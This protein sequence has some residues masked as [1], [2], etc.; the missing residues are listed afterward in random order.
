MDKTDQAALLH[1]IGFGEFFLKNKYYPWQEK[2]LDSLYRNKRTALK[3]ANGSGK[4]DKI[5]A[6]A[7]LWWLMG[8]DG[9]KALVTSASW[10]QI[11]TQ[12][13]PAICRHQD[14]FGPGWVINK[15]EIRRPNG[16]Q[17]IAR[18]TNEPGRFEGHH[19]NAENP[20]LIIVDESKTVSD[21]I[22]GAVNRC[23]YQRLLLTSSPGI[24][25]GYFYRAFTSSSSLFSCFTAT[26]FDCP[27]ISKDAIAETIKEYG[28]D[29]PYVRSK[30]YA[31]FMKDS[32]VG[33]WYKPVKLTDYERCLLDPPRKKI[34]DRFAYCDFA[35][36]GDEN[37]I[38]IMEGN[39]VLPLTCWRDKDTVRAAHDFIQKLRENGL[40][41]EDCYGDADGTGHGV[42]DNM[43]RAGFKINRV[44]N[45]SKARSDRY[46]NAGSEA[47]YE[48]GNAIRRK[49]VILPHDPVLREQLT[50][51]KGDRKGGEGKYY[52]QPKRELQKSPD[53]GDAVAGC[54]YWKSFGKVYTPDIDRKA[55]FQEMENEQKDL[56][57]E[58]LIGQGLWA[59]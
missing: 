6:S 19:G 13:W 9:A 27:H 42:M 31:E 56:N 43:D 57:Q 52:I 33:D 34:G 40:S 50:T 38:C 26:A 30:I 2:V 36:G 54:I 12:V 41:Q 39:E 14:K 4:T 53:R 7:V 44:R 28:E 47:W 51:R 22:F 49:E 48:A 11:A 20:L 35:A 5:I 58:E 32:G 10:D 8:F 1:P 25:E 3:A 16:S 23:T 15:D 17:C 29:D 21:E 24:E 37:V 18:S 59:G 46:F 45:G 55:L